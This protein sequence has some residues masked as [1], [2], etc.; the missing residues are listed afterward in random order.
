[1][2]LAAENS[3]YGLMIG[4]IISS[5]LFDVWALNLVCCEE[6][7]D[8]DYTEIIH[9]AR[10]VLHH[11]AVLER[12]AWVITNNRVVWKR[13]RIQTRGLAVGDLM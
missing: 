9:V 1:M 2:G 12:V 7:R 13:P 4:Q 3:C 8:G 5:I 10:I 6:T 11:R